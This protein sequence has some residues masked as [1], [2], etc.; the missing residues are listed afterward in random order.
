MS[1]LTPAPVVDT[2]VAAPAAPV[3]APEPIVAPDLSAATVDKA[4]TALA[5]AAGPFIPAKIRAT[6]YT[7]GSLV[8]VAAFAVAPVIGG[9]VG[10]VVDLVGGASVALTGALAISHVNK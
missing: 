5:T 8:S 4:V 6:I 1:E 7:V 3:A 2:P 10:V 9:H